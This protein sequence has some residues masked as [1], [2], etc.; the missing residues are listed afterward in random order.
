TVRGNTEVIV[1]EH[2]PVPLYQ[3]LMVKNSL[4]PLFVDRSG[5]AATGGK[6]NREL[7]RMERTIEGRDRGARGNPRRSRVQHPKLALLLEQAGLLPGIVFIFS[8]K[9]CDMAV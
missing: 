3:H 7:V 6:L 4:L 1:S 8:R 5:D 2:R 9:G